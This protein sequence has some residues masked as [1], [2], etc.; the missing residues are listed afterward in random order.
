MWFDRAVETQLRAAE[1]PGITDPEALKPEVVAATHRLADAAKTAD[2]D[3]VFGVLSSSF[4]LGPNHWRIGGSSWFTPLH[5]A[6]WHGAPVEVV[7]R[8]VELGAW[9]SLRNAAGDR[10]VD[11]ATARGHEHLLESLA[12][13]PVARQRRRKYDAWDRHLDT[14]VAERTDSLPPVRYRPVATEVLDLEP[15]DSLSFPYPGMYGGFSL[16]VHRGRLH[17]ESWCR[18]VGGSGQAHVITEGGC[19]L[20]EDGFV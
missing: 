4:W 6:A 1:W 12:S 11:V 3:A 18:V 9:R 17:V 19:V 7:D 15:L 10:P 14:L 8:L 13:P 16:T 2:W 5:Q 20:V